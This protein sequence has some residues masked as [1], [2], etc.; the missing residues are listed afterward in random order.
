MKVDSRLIL[1]FSGVAC[2]V[3]RIQQLNMLGQNTS[4]CKASKRS[5]AKN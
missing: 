4:L 2:E 3:S 5:P 1:I